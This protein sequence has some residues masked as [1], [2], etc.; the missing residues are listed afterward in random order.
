MSMSFTHTIT[1]PQSPA[2]VFAVLDDLSVAPQWLEKCKGLEKVS[3]GPNAKGTQ[4]LYTYHEMGHTGTMEG[5]IVA[6]VPNEHIAFHYDS[7]L[8]AIDA[9]FVI[10]P[11]GDG[12]SVSY[13]ISM[14]TKNMVAKLMQPVIRRDLPTQTVSASEA[15]RD[16]LARRY[17]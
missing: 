13:T 5:E 6:Y 9:D 16:F 15:L 14:A 3:A 7:R 8:L 10:T 1:V 11:D 12:A 17:A 2:Q 4:L